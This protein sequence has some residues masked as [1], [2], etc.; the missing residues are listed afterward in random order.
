M[1]IFTFSF[2]NW[3]KRGC[4]AKNQSRTYTSVPTFLLGIEYDMGT[5]PILIPKY[6]IFLGILG[7][8]IGYI[9]KKI[10][11]LGMSIG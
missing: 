10:G 9:P 11:F 2:V 4:L 8:D 6:S 5:Y 1:I 7:G 3:I